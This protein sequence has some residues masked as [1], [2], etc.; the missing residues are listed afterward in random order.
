[1][2]VGSFIRAVLKQYW[3]FAFLF[4]LSENAPAACPVQGPVWRFT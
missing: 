1:M 3:F 2:W 4:F